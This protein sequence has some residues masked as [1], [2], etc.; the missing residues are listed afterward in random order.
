MNVGSTSATP[1]PPVTQ[2]TAESRE[3]KKSG[4]DNDGDADDGGSKSVQSAP[5]TSVNLQGQTLGQLINTSA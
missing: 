3:V 2:A 5:Q 4:P 1:P